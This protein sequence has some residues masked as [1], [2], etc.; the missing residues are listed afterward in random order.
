MAAILRAKRKKGE[1]EAT[2]IKNLTAK[3]LKRPQGKGP[4]TGKGLSEKGRTL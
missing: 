1:E 3:G 4:L 2:G